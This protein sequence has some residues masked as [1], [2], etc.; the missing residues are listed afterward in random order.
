MINV[1]KNHSRA[2]CYSVW[3]GQSFLGEVIEDDIMKLLGDE[4][5]MF[6]SEGKVNFLVPENLIKSV[7]NK[8]KYY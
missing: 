4:A 5:E 1:Y 8:P 6:Y 2:F 3:C 7:V